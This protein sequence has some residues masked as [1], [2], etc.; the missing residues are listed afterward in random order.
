MADFQRR[1]PTLK[2]FTEVN[3]AQAKPEVTADFLDEYA[4]AW[5]RH[6]VDAILAAMTEDCVMETSAGPE[7]CGRAFHGQAEVRK[8]IEA[9]FKQYPDAQWVGS[10][11]FIAEARGVTEWTFVAT[12]PEGARTESKGCDVFR[13]RDGKI[14]EKSSFRKIRTA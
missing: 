8:G 13:F 2:Y 11:H 4:Q 10:R 9:F 12:G 6:D 5:N 14:S 1:D 7:V 3:L